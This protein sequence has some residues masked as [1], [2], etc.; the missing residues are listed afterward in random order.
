MKDPE[1]HVRKNKIMNNKQYS[2]EVNKRVQT[3]KISPWIR[4]EKK[5][6]VFVS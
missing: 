4:N 3:T 5:P 6:M 2:E 1:I